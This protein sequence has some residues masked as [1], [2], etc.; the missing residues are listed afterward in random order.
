MKYAIILL[1]AFQ[2]SIA[3]HSSILGELSKTEYGFK[4]KDMYIINDFFEY[5]KNFEN[6]FDIK[7]GETI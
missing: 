2:Y 3:Q 7:N 6:F 5:K 1:L 4:K